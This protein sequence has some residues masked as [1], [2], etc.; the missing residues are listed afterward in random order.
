MAT[1]YKVEGMTCGGCASAVKKAITAEQADAV[2]EINVEA[3]TVTVEPGDDALVAR[4]VEAAGFDF[5][6][7]AA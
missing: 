7:V 4:A 1:T 6:G 5:Q 2:V 3:G